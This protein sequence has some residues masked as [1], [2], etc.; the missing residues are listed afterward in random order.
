MAL[1]DSAGTVGV[2]V[3]SDPNAVLATQWTEW[4]IPLGDFAGVNPAGVKTMYVGLGDRNAPTPG[5]AGVITV[6]DIRI[7]K[8]ESNNEQE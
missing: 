3:H 1:E 4:N 7:T 8:P 5:G 6:D 2:A